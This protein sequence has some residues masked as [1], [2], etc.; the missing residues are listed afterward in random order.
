[1]VLYTT[2]VVFITII[3]ILMV[4]VVLLQRGQAPGMT[5]GIGGGLAGGGGNNMMGSRR[6]A[7]FL[8]KTTAVLAALFLT[9]SVLANFFIDHDTQGSAI[10]QHGADMPGEAPPP[11]EPG[12]EGAEPF[13]QEAEGD[14][15][16]GA[17]P[18]PEGGGDDAPALDVDPGEDD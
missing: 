4:I 2:I 3:S 8:S 10:Q 17:Q 14:A 5:G 9:L 13:Q 18:V 7:D 16:P 1:M 12:A 6:T 15:E 11:M